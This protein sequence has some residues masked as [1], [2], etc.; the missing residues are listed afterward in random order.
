[1]IQTQTWTV[2][3]KTTLCT[4]LNMFLSVLGQIRPSFWRYQ[5]GGGP[6]RC[7]WAI[8]LLFFSPGNKISDSR[9]SFFCTKLLSFTTDLDPF[10]LVQKICIL[11][12]DS[13][14]AV[15]ETLDDWCF[16]QWIISTQKALLVVSR[17]CALCSGPC[18]ST[19]QPGIRGN[20]TDRHWWVPRTKMPIPISKTRPGHP[21]RI[22]G[23]WLECGKV[24]MR[25]E[26]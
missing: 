9:R 13:T 8:L 16:I 2:R 17:E 3:R 20:I 24:A 25:Q 4:L 15:I 21:F 6:L 12:Y 26:R 11:L 5:W 14:W 1:M 10:S 23:G 19:R 7:N 18:M 22:K